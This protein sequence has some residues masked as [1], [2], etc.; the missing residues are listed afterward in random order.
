MEMAKVTHNLSFA[1]IAHN[2]KGETKR[3]TCGVN[4]DLAAWDSERDAAIFYAFEEREYLA[5]DGWH[6][7]I[8]KHI[9]VTGLQ[10]L[11]DIGLA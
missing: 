10:K 4:I 2:V 6:I 5:K 8:P 7:G 9:E 1:F 3:F 11:S